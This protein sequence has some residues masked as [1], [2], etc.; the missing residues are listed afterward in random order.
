MTVPIRPKV[1]EDLAVVEID[2]EAVIYDE[3]SGSLHHL[4]PSAAL[5]FGMFDGTATIRELAG[6]LQEAFG[7]DAGDLE[8]QVR[9]LHRQF[10]AQGL[11]ANRRGASHG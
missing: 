10:R 1:R 6:D 4:N 8:Q 7:V 2:G 5:V 11:L 9:S 3:E